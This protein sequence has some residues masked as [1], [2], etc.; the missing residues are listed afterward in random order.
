MPEELSK[1]KEQEMDCSFT[2]DI[3]GNPICAKHRT[4]LQERSNQAD[5]P[6]PPGVGHYSS[7]KCPV[8]GNDVHDAGF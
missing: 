1:V 7:W 3:D 5:Q 2:R 6:N 4:R 8:T